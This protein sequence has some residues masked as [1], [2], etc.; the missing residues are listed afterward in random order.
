MTSRMPGTSNKHP[1]VTMLA[2]TVL[3]YDGRAGRSGP[4]GMGSRI[5]KPARVGDRTV[6]CWA[7]RRRFLTRWAILI[8]IVS[9]CAAQ[10]GQPG[11]PGFFLSRRDHPQSRRALPQQRGPGPLPLRCRASRGTTRSRLATSNHGQGA[12]SV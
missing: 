4:A 5:A 7:G 11:T 1:V 8:M 2:F 12:A 9:Y 3:G 6:T 10:E